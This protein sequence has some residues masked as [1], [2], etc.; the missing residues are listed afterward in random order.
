MP[1]GAKLHHRLQP[2]FFPFAKRFIAGATLLEALDVVRRL[3][4]QGF[5]T[6]LDFLGENITTDAEAH[7]AT[8]QNLSILQ[9]LA[10]QKLN[11]NI[12]VKPTMLGLSVGQDLFE[13]NLRRVAEKAHE[14]GAFVRVDME[15]SATTIDT[16]TVVKKIKGPYA[17][18]GTVVQA[19]LKRTP[20]DVIDLLNNH[21]SLRLCKG[22][23]KEPAAI[24]LQ[25]KDELRAQYISL[26]KQL[27]TSNLYHGIATHDDAIIEA[28]ISFVRE[29]RLDK[30]SFEF[31]MLYG[32][33]R[34]LQEKLRSLG[35]GIR[36]YVPFG[37]AW[38]PYVVRRLRERKENVWFVVRNLFQK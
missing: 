22:A 12:S 8:E 19:M 34:D 20:H 1:I 6:T 30:T 35:F 13:K 38:L 9:A 25:D 27:L 26:A 17:P 18:I 10:E 2:L 24:A 23:Y 16:L 32:V 4:T 15:G 31:Q 33:R 36:I 29:Q 14:L 37:N 21:I 3:N 5:L 11:L 7:E 28:L